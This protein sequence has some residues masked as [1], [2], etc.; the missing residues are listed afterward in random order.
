[1]LDKRHPDHAR[2]AWILK[3]AP[4]GTQR[5]V[6]GWVR[7]LRDQGNFAFLE[8]NDGSSVSNLQVILE[9]HLAPYSEWMK[10][11]RTGASVEV[12]G[13]VV[14]SPGT[15]QR[16]E[17]KA[18]D[19]SIIGTC[20]AEEYPLQKKRHSTEFLR[21]IAHL[22][23]R[24]NLTGA[25]TRIRNALAFAI[26][27]F[28]QERGFLYIQTPIIT[29]SDCEGGGDL[30]RVTTLDLEKP[31]R[32]ADGKVDNSQDFFGQPTYLT[33]SGQLEGECYALALTDI[34]TFG[35][36]FRAENSNTS[37]HLA[38]FWMVEPEMAFA[39]LQDNMDLAESFLKFV[40]ASTLQRCPEDFAFFNQWVKPGVLD[41]LQKVI[42]TP[43]RRISY[44]EA[45]E[46]L[47]KS[48]HPFE[49]PCHWGAD[50]QSEHERYLCEEIFKGPVI[51]YN[52]PKEIKA[53]YMR[54]NDDGKT[55]AAMDFLCPEVGELMGG[56]QREDRVELLKARMESSGLDQETYGW[57][58]Q[59][60]E[61]GSAPHAGFGVGFERLVQFATG[62]D[63][64]RDCI[65]FPRYPGHAE[66]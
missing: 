51:V 23:P 62:I 66:F 4:I 61:Y 12:L 11:L 35:P 65:P 38:E 26:H 57:Y 5:K 6:Y 19:L 31:P 28:F 50:L 48:Q 27:T 3:D 20:P 1:M 7:T 9:S 30:F 45:V 13:E 8:I 47:Q 59:L 22:R 21:T 52:Y 44:T 43:C 15:K 58:L 24:T 55:V 32:D 17:L 2:I 14:A 25:M 18:S 41:R 40:L 60:R 29:S 64:I 36:T 49:F 34:Y 39:T 46:L 42:Q 10:I 53:F 56:A 37:R 33:V 63:N 16:V 54:A